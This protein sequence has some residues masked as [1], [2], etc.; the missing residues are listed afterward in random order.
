VP[1]TSSHAP[2]RAYMRSGKTISVRKAILVTAGILAGIAALLIFLRWLA[3]RNFPK[4]MHISELNVVNNRIANALASQ[5][6][7][8]ADGELP[9]VK[10]DMTGVNDA[11]QKSR[12]LFLQQE[13]QT[14]LL[15]FQVLPRTASDLQ[16]LMRKP[17]LS[18]R[19]KSELKALASDCKIIYLSQ[20]SYLLNCDGWRPTPSV[21]LSDVI[22][23][24]DQSNGKLFS[25]SGHVFLFLPSM[26]QVAT[27]PQ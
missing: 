6:Q 25:R 5:V 16:A 18:A 21:S 19:D 17:S 15:W 2:D 20:D 11:E 27:S 13:I 1:T 9:S 12:L 22:A 10:V 3:I 14:Y 4:D 8:L 7:R 23:S 24:T 26:F